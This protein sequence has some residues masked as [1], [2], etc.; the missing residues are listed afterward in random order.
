M[1]NLTFTRVHWA[2]WCDDAD[3]ATDISAIMSKT[4]LDALFDEITQAFGVAPLIAV[5]LFQRILALS[6]F[7][8]DGELPTTLFDEVGMPG[9]ELCAAAAKTWIPNMPDETG[10]LMS[11]CRW[12]FSRHRFR[13]PAGGVVRRGATDWVLAIPFRAFGLHRV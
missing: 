12:C 1:K 13:S 5:A 11:C 3:E 8:S 10:T 7:C 9:R 2:P 6:T 4:E